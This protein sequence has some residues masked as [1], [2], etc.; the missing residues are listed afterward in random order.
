MAES[1]S[2]VTVDAQTFFTLQMAQFDNN[3]A[4]S[5]LRKA[6]AAV[7]V[8]KAKKIKTQSILDFNID[9]VEQQQKLQQQQQNQP[10]STNPQLQTEKSEKS[11]KEHKLKIR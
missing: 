4:D 2:Q 8:A 3:I 1:Q 6:E 7:E 5:E 10:P 9:L 11:K